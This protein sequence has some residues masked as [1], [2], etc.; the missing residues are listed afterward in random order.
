MKRFLIVVLL[1]LLV[2]GGLAFY[3][4]SRDNSF[5]D[6]MVS[7]KAFQVGAFT[8]YDNAV[9]VAD[10]NNGIVVNDDGIYR[11]YVAILSDGEAIEKM[12]SYYDD[13]GLNYYLK[14][15]SVS[16]SFLDS[17]KNSEELLVDSSRDAY[18]VINLSVIRKY[19][20]ML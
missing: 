17:I 9:K 7:V 1:A 12:K 5:F 10:R 6:E 8:S 19:E 4:F 13:I 16:K 14:E 15:I 3:V 18:K 20:E 11:V 2:G